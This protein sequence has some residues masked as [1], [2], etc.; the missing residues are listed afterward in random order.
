M[1]TYDLLALALRSAAA[2]VWAAGFVLVI[3]NHIV[4]T[5]SRM[6]LATGSLV[7]L[8]IAIVYGGLVAL[9]VAPPDIARTMYTAVAT[10][11][12]ISGLAFMWGDR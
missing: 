8:L 2:F 11:I 3:T 4:P 12:L 5:H 1:S 6:V 7:A 10:G 9:G